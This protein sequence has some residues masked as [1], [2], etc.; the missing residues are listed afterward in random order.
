MTTRTLTS[1]SDYEDTRG[2]LVAQSRGQLSTEWQPPLQ[3]AETLVGEYLFNL[4]HGGFDNVEGYFKRKL[5]I[6][7]QDLCAALA[8]AVMHGEW[9]WGAL[10]LRA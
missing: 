4:A 7:D 3:V 8:G 1:L 10:R 6:A 9:C 5:N 2:F